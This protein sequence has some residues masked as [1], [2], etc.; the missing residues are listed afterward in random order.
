MPM[1]CVTQEIIFETEIEAPSQALAIKAFESWRDLG[2]DLSELGC[3]TFEPEGW[4]SQAKMKSTQVCCGDPIEVELMDEYEPDPENI[5]D[6]PSIRQSIE[7][8]RK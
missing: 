6:E 1:Y 4:P 3:V 7:E 2:M 5:Y 8:D